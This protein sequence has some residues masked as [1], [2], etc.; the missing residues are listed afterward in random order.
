MSTTDIVQITQTSITLVGT[1]VLIETVRLL[2]RDLGMQ[3]QTVEH[4]TG[5]WQYDIYQR[6]DSQVAN[7]L[8]KLSDDP[9]LHNVYLP[10]TAE[11]RARLDAAQATGKW[12]AW[13]S[14]SDDEAICYR[15]IRL[16]LENL[17]QA[18]EIR[19]KGWMSE[20][21]WQ[22]WQG[23]I[24]VW[25]ETRYFDYVLEDQR[26]RLLS[27]FVAELDEAVRRRPAKYGPPG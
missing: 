12:G 10:L 5:A 23:W 18:W 19:A 13:E 24:E 11:E 14:L 6:L 4:Q 1:I 27:G 8:W 15:F 22:K 16:F 17:E 3:K 9:R 26:P 20:E 2:R 7:M 21:M 25:C